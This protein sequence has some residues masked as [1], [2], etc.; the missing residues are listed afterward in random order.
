M[1]VISDF[2]LNIY[3]FFISHIS[4]Y[5]KFRDISLAIFIAFRDIS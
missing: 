3:T 5:D 4:F 1:F 2:T